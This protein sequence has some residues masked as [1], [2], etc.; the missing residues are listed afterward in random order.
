MKAFLA[1]TRWRHIFQYEAV[2]INMSTE[3]GKTALMFAATLNSIQNLELVKYLISAG[4]D[5]EAVDRYGETVIHKM[6]VNQLKYN[7]PG[8]KGYTKI[9][10]HLVKVG[11]ASLNIPDRR[12][13]FPIQHGFYVEQLVGL[14][15]WVNV[16]TED[17]DNLL[18]LGIEPMDIFI[19]SGVALDARNE[20]GETPVFK[21]KNREDVKK[22]AEAGASLD[23]TNNEEKT[24]LFDGK[25]GKV[26]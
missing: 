24:V 10:N 11:G 19:A 26:I 4:A 7:H 5:V 13:M 6:I 16:T 23:I 8:Y 18:H 20:K 22:L 1:K 21:A 15:A 14:G 9:L 17:G 3:E 25:N 2:D 12:G